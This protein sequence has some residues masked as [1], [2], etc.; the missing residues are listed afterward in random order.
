MEQASTTQTLN[1][2]IVHQ[3]SYSRGQLLLRTFLGFFYM[4]LPHAIV[5][6][7]MGIA[8]LLVGFVAWWAVLFTAKYPRGLYDFQV[9]LLRWK[10]RL[11]ARLL[12]LADGYPAFGLSAEDPSINFSISYPEKLSRGVLLL[13]AF[14]GH[15]Y[16]LIPHGIVLALRGIACYF[17]IFIAWWAVLI[18]GKFPKG[19]HDFIV[20][21]LRWGTRVNAYMAFLTDQYPPFSGK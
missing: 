15:F 13:R 12:N 14:L 18:T 20:D 9:T 17:L 10:I 21:T 5:L 2:D 1:F 16:V 11:N 3:E 8:S 4:I 7:F 19:M 6:M